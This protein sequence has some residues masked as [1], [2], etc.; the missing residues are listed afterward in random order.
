MCLQNLPYSIFSFIK[1]GDHIV[2]KAVGRMM[3]N[4]PTKAAQMCLPLGIKP[5]DCS[6]NAM[7]QVNINVISDH[8]T[9]IDQLSE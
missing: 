9:L 7:V 4:Y 3:A 1:E 5:G 6:S 8:L 2:F